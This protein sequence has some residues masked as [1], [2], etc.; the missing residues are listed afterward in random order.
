MY[1]LP[2]FYMG[3]RAMKSVPRRRAALVNII[4]KGVVDIKL[5]GV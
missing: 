3:R 4:S 1:F 2:S 5:S